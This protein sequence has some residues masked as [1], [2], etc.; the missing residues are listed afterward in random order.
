VCG[1]QVLYPNSDAFVNATVAAAPSDDKVKVN[2]LGYHQT[3]EVRT[4]THTHTHTHMHTCT[5]A[6]R[7]ARA[8]THTHTHKR[9]R[10]HAHPTSC[11]VWVYSA[12]FALGA[13]IE[14]CVCVCVCVC[15]CVRA[16]VRRWRRHRFGRRS[17]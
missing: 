17:S 12:N 7:R 10:A 3:I 9:A 13:V 1:A 15:A 16:C 2:L 8:H 11:S 14:M 6:R 5:H 4:H